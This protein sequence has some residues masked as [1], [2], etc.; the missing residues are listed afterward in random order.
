MSRSRSQRDALAERAAAVGAG[1][2]AGDAAGRRRLAHGAWLTALGALGAGALGEE[3]SVRAALWV[4]ML[5]GLL[6]IA[7]LLRSPLPRIRALPPAA[8]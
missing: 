4:G 5:G 6:G 3:L 8:G 7:I 2:G 1:A